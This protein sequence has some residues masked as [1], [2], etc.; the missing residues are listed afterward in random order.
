MIKAAFFSLFSMVMLSPLST[1]RAME[2]LSTEELA[3]HCAHYAEG[4]DH[5]ET[6]AIFCIRYIQ[7]FI[8][9]AIATDEKVAQNVE[10]ELS[11]KE[12][13]TERAFRTRVSERE[14]TDP[15]YYAD[16]CL[17]SP[18]PLHDVVDE[19]VQVLQNKH[20]ASRYPDARSAVYGVLLKAYPCKAE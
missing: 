2:A 13:F 16:F 7:G 15:T 10:V 5:T 1:V 19:V 14:R 9:G 20:I 11:Q 4:V 3:S 12:T 18:V 6:D 8:D 17:G